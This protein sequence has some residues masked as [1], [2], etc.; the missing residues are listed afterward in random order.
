MSPKT[1]ESLYLEKLTYDPKL[2]DSWFAFFIERKRFLFLLII[3]IV[4]AGYLGL[5]ALPLESNPE[6]SIGVGVVSVALPGG[7]PEVMEDLVT[8]KLEKEISKIKG[9]DTMTSTSMNS[10]S[11]IS[12]QFKSDT[13]T[14]TAMRDLKDKVDLVK[15]KLPAD[16]K[17][18][19]VTEVSFDDTPIWTFSLAGKYDGFKLR[20]YATTIQE[21]LE[22]NVLVSDVTISGGDETEYGVFIDPK[23]LDAYGLTIGA[24]NS[25]LAAENFTVPIGQYDIGSYTHSFTVD[26]RYYTVASLRDLVIAKTG[27]TGIIRLSDI[28]RV[29][30]VAKK[31]T[32][33]ARLS[34]KGSNPEN[35]VTLGVVKKKG[36]SIVNLVTEGEK[37]I[38]DLRTS[39][40][41]PA[42]VVITTVLDQ[43]ERIKLDLSHLI[44]DGL[45]TVALVF[46]T[47]FLIIGVREA[48]VAGA[49]VPLVFLITFAVMAGFHQTLNFLSMFALILSLGLLVDDAIVVISAFN[50]YHRTGKFTPKQAALLVLRDYKQVLT[51][52][53]LTVVWIFS[54][55]LFMTGLI[56]KFI[57]SIPFVITVTLIASLIIALT[58][59][60]ALAVFFVGH[61]DEEKKPSRWS[62]IL[63]K[64]LISIH[65]LEEFYARTIDR[66]LSTRKKAKWFVFG[67]FLFFLSA[68]AL[69]ISGALKS[70]FFPKTD[71]DQ[72]FIN[73]E[74]EAGTKLD[75]TSEITKQVETLL[76]HEKEIA[77]FSTAIGSQV[78][79]GR[80]SGGGGNGSNFAGISINLLKKEYG[81]KESSIS[82]ADR[83][84]TEVKAIHDAKVSVV[85]LAGGPP[86]GAD[87]ELK[88]SGA[89]FRVMEQIAADIKKI[90][91]S[92]PG[93][94]NIETSRKP[95][96]LEF[97]LS[98]D[99]TK[100]A[101]YNLTLPQVSLFL[102]NVIDGTDA[103]TIY[104]GNDEIAVRTR[105]ETGSTDT[106]DKIKDLKV[107]NLLG[108]DVFIRDILKTEF[109][110][111]VFSI[112]R[113]DQKRVISVTA[114]AAAGATAKTLLAD[115]TAKT[116]DYKIP[117]GYEFSTGGANEENAKSV[118]SLLIA[119]VFGMFFI[120]ATLVI[121]FDS[122]KQSVIVLV[123]IPLSL[124]G[125]F[126]GLT[127]FGQALSFPGLIGL[128]A[129]F[130][131][132][133]RNG[134]IL[135][136]KINLNRRE[137]IS[138]RES[139]IDGGK[140]RLE[141]V[142]LTSVCTVLGMIPLTLSNPTWT[143]LGLSIIF[144]LSVS[145]IFTLLVLPA[146]YFLV[147][148]EK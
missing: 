73:V 129:L 13:D 25:T 86:A 122:Y 89:D 96:P 99:S 27:T 68:L 147:V 18:P 14:A 67:V 90:M 48:L 143:S 31:R 49:A 29:E 7:S 124:I 40:I 50:Q 125:V 3:I 70:D 74:T 75:V 140:S 63:N 95:L 97:R 78:S 100:L 8:K 71:A 21:E 107:K 53:T 37:A 138:F 77:S 139:V 52:T 110:P 64:G 135:F 11:V 98:F 44:R 4:I 28:A 137:G 132:V 61:S 47:L 38:Q 127:L 57:F 108:Q 33:I 117:A 148:K 87:F 106:I 84:R 81:R 54:A 39:G 34:D 2:D 85:E 69:P 15:P 24:V 60:P 45:I 93:A 35:A 16:A 101:L 83:L 65:P 46:I 22:K 120:V 131:I 20:E 126:Y 91:L 121:L 116:K 72:I 41:I 133:V 59:N 118:Q 88:I 141:P 94:I 1:Q 119:M 134:I 51:S 136:D 112:S 19:T 66:L 26:E 82:I 145:T 103:T 43:S 123:T 102:K 5:K 104:K 62:N 23:K 142:F 144:G 30:E 58:I 115:F 105:Y 9:I 17:D 56:G 80:T 12:V 114:S 113:I 79:V 76:L 130:G 36:G 109:E 55:M 111:S 42:D 10:V 92:V 32:T 146:L 6:V 128:V